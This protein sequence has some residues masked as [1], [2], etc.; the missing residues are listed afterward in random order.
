MGLDSRG[1]M[2]VVGV[3]PIE[4]TSEQ[5]AAEERASARRSW[6]WPR[7][8][9]AE[10]GLRNYWY[11]ALLAH[12]LKQKPIMRKMLGEELVFVRDGGR[13]YCIQGRCAHRGVPLS[14][15]QREFP[16]TLT[17]P[18]HGWTYDL[19]S[20]KLVAAL[21]DGPD[22]AI[23]GKVKLKTYPAVERQGVIWA[24]IGDERGGE[25]GAP[26]PPPLEDDVPAEFLEPGAYVGGRVFVWK[27]D[28][29]VAMEGAIDPSHPFYLH[30]SAWLSA[31]FSMPAARGK[32]FPEI[33]DNRYLTYSTELPLP[34]GDYPGLGRWPR[35]SWY[36]RQKL[37]KLFV[38]GALPCQSR[39]VGL[40]FNLPFE[41]YSW[42]VPVDRAH[43]RWFT[44]LV[45][46]GASG[47]KRLKAWLKYNL[48][49]KWVY[50]GQFLRQDSL[51]N[52]VMA[53]FY[54]DQDGWMKER[55]HRPDVVITAWRKFVEENA[56]GIQEPSG[57]A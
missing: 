33:L 2:A 38:T 30:R 11:P 52:E 12:R 8:L 47:T 46:R 45:A 31:P 55:L 39:V 16:C 37:A 29:R 24:F 54:L 51:M 43:Y 57:R 34:V 40:N 32:H 7:Y 48:W 20:G 56:R 26:W 36:K 19:A 23:V 44:F 53:P 3:G 27:G 14:L 41:T 25:T 28:W 6:P 15:G 50:Q 1:A 9:R 13:V 5:V 17:C 4:E 10:L 22:S 42:Y 21:T 35:E 18:Y 49:L